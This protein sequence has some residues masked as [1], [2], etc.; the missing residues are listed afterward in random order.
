MIDKS[1]TL[2]LD[3]DGV[4]N[5]EKDNDYILHVGEFSFYDGVLQAMP[6]FSRLFGTIV[7]VTNQ[8]GI[9]K[10]RMTEA[11]L[12]GIHSYMVTEIVNNGGRLDKIYF[13]PD[14][15]ADAFNRKPNPGMAHQAKADF[16]QIDFTRSVMVGNKLTDMQ[17]GRN[18]GIAHTVF[19]ATT[20]PETPFPHP[21]V[22]ERFNSLA[23]Y[24]THLEAL[25]KA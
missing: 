19:L 14:L 8:K 11:D 13:A 20:N 24:A 10:G 5:P 6:V 16:P 23:A 17:F 7:L 12:A 22:D 4:I 21:L 25:T 1:W 9:G 18:A 15:D 2:F 3:R